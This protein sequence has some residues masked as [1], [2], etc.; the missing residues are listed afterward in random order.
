MVVTVGRKPLAL[1]T[2]AANAIAHHTGA[3]CIDKT[4]ILALDT[5]TEILFSLIQGKESFSIKQLLSQLP[6]WDVERIH[7]AIDALHVIQREGDTCTV[8]HPITGVG[9]W[10][11]NMILSHDTECLPNSP[12]SDSCAIATLDMEVGLLQSGATRKNG[13]SIGYAGGGD[14]YIMKIRE[15]RSGTASRYFKQIYQ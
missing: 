7:S 12:C 8:A 1:G 3:L 9:R 6:E 4:R 15:A 11:A 14:L 10:P 2:V 5:D 13:F